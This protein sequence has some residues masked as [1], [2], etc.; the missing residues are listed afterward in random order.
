[1][2]PQA[3]HG[4]GDDDVWVLLL[5][6]DGGFSRY[7]GYVLACPNRFLPRPPLRT[8]ILLMTRR[9]LVWARVVVE[10]A[11]GESA[12]WQVLFAVYFAFLQVFHAFLPAA[13]LLTARSE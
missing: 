3:L 12:Q 5:Y 11:A 9:A 6:G 2:R 1:M 8:T 10:V 7:G 4:V 13:A